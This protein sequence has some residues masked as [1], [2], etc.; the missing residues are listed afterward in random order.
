M[1]IRTSSVRMPTTAS[2]SRSVSAAANRWASADSSWV[3]RRRVLPSGERMDARARLSWVATAS[4]DVSSICR[5]L[6]RGEA[7]D[8]PQHEDGATARAQRLHRRQKSE[9]HRLPGL[10]GGL[11]TGGGRRQLV[12]EGVRVRL[13]PG[14]L[15]RAVG[16]G[17][18]VRRRSGRLRAPAGGST[19]VEADV[20]RH[21]VQPGPD[22]RLG[23]EPTDPAPRGEQRVLE[24]ILGVVVRARASGSSARAARDGTASRAR[25]RRHGHRVRAC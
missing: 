6:A 1:A 3:G 5:D 7:Q 23:P 2:T 15:V 9:G 19:V 16:S 8:V 21:A 11:R 17:T 13:Q 25:R 10:D 24:G 12:E 22:R 18:V 20:R 14:D 4:D